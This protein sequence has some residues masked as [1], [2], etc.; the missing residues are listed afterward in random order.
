MAKVMMLFGA[1][2]CESYEEA[3][4]I[5]QLFKNTKDAVYTMDHFKEQVLLQIFV[6]AKAKED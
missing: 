6:P 5:V 2:W 3:K 1:W 4:R